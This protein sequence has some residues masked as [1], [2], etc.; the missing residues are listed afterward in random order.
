MK[1]DIIPEGYFTT[2]QL[3]KAWG[4]SRDTVNREIRRN[5]EAGKAEQDHFKI[6]TNRVGLY[7]VAHYRFIKQDK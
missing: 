3:M 5:I 6:A 1:P 2:Q 7:P 4:V